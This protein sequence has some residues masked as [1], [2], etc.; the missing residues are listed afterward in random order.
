MRRK[1]PQSALEVIIP[2]YRE[3]LAIE[4]RSSAKEAP[5]KSL[6]YLLDVVDQSGA[7]SYQRF[8]L[9]LYKPNGEI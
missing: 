9:D 1:P 8:V 7:K 6:A 3:M 2:V 4:K 5:N